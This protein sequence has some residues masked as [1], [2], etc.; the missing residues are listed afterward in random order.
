MAQDVVKFY[1]VK[2]M[3]AILKQAEPELY[4]QFRKDARLIA[5]PAVSAVRSSIPTVAPLSGMIGNGRVSWSPAKVTLSIT[6]G[7]RSRAFGSTTANL[8]AIITRGSTGQGLVIAD[9]AGKG[10]STNKR[11]KTRAYPYKGGTRQHRING[12][13]QAMI[14]NLP[15]RPSRFVYPPME[16]KLPEIRAEFAK[17]VERMAQ[18]INYKIARM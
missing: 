2:E 16:R 12:Q 4:K 1:G 8:A 18:T 5:A 15:G 7:Q 13:G 11:L 10:H 14:R 17:S 6:P 9:M 3:I